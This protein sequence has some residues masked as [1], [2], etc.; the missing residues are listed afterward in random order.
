MFWPLLPA[1]TTNSCPAS[2]APWISPF[3]KSL[4]VGLCGR[5]GGGGRGNWH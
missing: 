4:Q 2:A 3:K 1:A 5:R